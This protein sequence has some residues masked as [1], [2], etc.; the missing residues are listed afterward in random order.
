[1]SMEVPAEMQSKAPATIPMWY[2]DEAAGLWKEEGIAKLSGR[3]YTANVAHFTYWNYDAWFPIVK[4]TASFVYE[5][6]PASNVSV[7]ITI[8]ELETRKCASTNEDGV[9]CGMVAAD[10]LLLM[11]VVDPC[12][13]VV[14]S[15]EIG[16]FSDSTT[17]GPITIAESAVT[18]TTINGSAADCDGT[19]VTN[20]FARIHVGQ[21][22]HYVVLNESDGTFEI[23]VMNCD[24]SDV[25]I[26]VIDEAALKQS[27]PQSYGYAATIDAGVITACEELMEL[28]V[29]DVEGED[30]DFLFLFPSVYVDQ[31]WTTISTQ[32]S[33][34]SNAFFY[35][36]FQGDEPGT[37]EI[38][39]MEIGME[40]SGGDYVFATQATVVISYFGDVG[41]FIQG[42]ISGV[43][44]SDPQGSGAEYNFTGTIS[45]LRQ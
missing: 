17:M 25:M 20:G 7:C 12:G 29:L 32:D 8:L 28:I 41:D 22:N 38:T 45:A 26:T 16:P 34:G 27:L 44:K 39:G 43:L 35:I 30:D 18:L 9:V 36:G 24:Q 21:R 14:Y 37:Y 6:G 3:V 33:S 31:G 40:L 2:F 23:T 13:N 42:T 5:N 15:E 11:E 10:E 19:P 1:M 4:W